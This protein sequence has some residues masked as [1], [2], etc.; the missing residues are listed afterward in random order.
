MQVLVKKTHTMSP[1]ILG[2]IGLLHLESEVSMKVIVSKQF[3]AL[4]SIDME[5]PASNNGDKRP[6]FPDRYPAVPHRGPLFVATTGVDKLAPVTGWQG[7]RM[8]GAVPFQ[9]SP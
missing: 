9:K 4:P 2:L 8:R 6:W 7:D 3:H 1:S 5:G